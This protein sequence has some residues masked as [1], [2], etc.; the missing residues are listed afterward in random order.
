[1]RHIHFIAEF[2]LIWKVVGHQL[3]T[4]SPPIFDCVMLY[5]C[6]MPVDLQRRDCTR[7]LTIRVLV[8]RHTEHKIGG[9][10]LACRVCI[11]EDFLCMPKSPSRQSKH[12][13]HPFRSETKAETSFDDPDKEQPNFNTSGA[14]LKD[15]NTVNGVILKYSEPAEARMP[16]DKLRLYVFKGKEQLE[17]LYIHKQSAYLFGRDRK[18]ADIPTDHPSCSK[19]HC[20]L[21]YRQIVKKNE[22]G[23]QEKTIK[24]YLIDLESANG[25]FVNKKKIAPSR[26]Y[27][28]LPGDTITFG[29]STRD[30]VLISENMLD[31]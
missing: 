19:Q 27:E 13:N 14:L 4:D 6:T 1:M 20:V 10:S 2:C 3:T 30:Y 16:V 24:P 12:R 11:S 7:G 18:V 26:Y 21:Q 15:T 8:T 25:T 5:S 23:D 31:E 22:F 17:T 9:E 28:L 29:S